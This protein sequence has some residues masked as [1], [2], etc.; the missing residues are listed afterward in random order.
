VEIPFDAPAG[1]RSGEGTVTIAPQSVQAAAETRYVI[2]FTAGP[3][4]LAQGGGFRIELPIDPVH[5][6]LGFLPPHTGRHTLR[7][8]VQCHVQRGDA[9]RGEAIAETV[10]GEARCLLPEGRLP[11]GSRIVMEYWALASRVAGE[12]SLHVESRFSGGGGGRALAALPR[13]EVTPR[14]ARALHVVLPSTVKA[15][16]P[17]TLAVVALDDFGNRASDYLGALEIELAGARLEH[18]FTP[19]ERGVALLPGLAIERPGFYRAIVKEKGQPEGPALET[20][21]NPVKVTNGLVEE[22]F[23]GDLHFHTGTGAAGRAFQRA[24]GLSG[25]HRGNY[26]LQQEAY[27]YGRDVMRLDFAAATE[28]AGD[29]MMGEAWQASMKAAGEAHDPPRFTTFNGYQ[30]RDR[31]VI[32]PGDSGPPPRSPWRARDPFGD[33]NHSLGGG[34]EGGAFMIALRGGAAAAG[35]GAVEIYSWRNRGSEYEDRPRAFEPD[36]SWPAEIGDLPA[37]LAAGSDNHWGHPGAIDLTG[38]EPGS[39]GLTAVRASV[40]DREGIL[41]ALRR[42]HAWATTGAR[43]YLSVERRGGALEVEAAGSARLTGIDL[44]MVDRDGVREIAA[45]EEPGLQ[46]TGLV[47]LPHSRG[48]GFCYVRAVQEDGE[49]AWSSPISLGEE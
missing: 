48:R 43:I 16:D 5:P 23:W 12:R 27:A 24:P 7:G 49:I 2:T 20:A 32:L 44:L 39:G 41:G 31:L 26:T 40:N 36:G 1:P 4:G 42:G 21:S 25:D 34:P 10:G 35:A 3:S 28:H 47:D 6:Y 45:L 33:L 30:W 17:M 9:D 14:P 11:A 38:L 46:F 13:V 8:H 18:R 15:G 22:V 37:S 19:E 29:A